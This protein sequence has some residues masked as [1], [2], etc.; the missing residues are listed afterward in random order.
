[1]RFSLMFLEVC[2]RIPLG[3]RFWRFTLVF[4]GFALSFPA[5]ASR[6]V[7]LF[8]FRILFPRRARISRVPLM[9]LAG[10]AT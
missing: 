4:A 9:S 7:R 6:M 1:M 8:A 3:S 5:Q 10:R 2:S